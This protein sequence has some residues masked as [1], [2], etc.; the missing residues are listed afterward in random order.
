[1]AQDAATRPLTEV[2]PA[3]LEWLAC[4]WGW[5]TTGRDARPHRVGSRSRE[6]FLGTLHLL[7]ACAVDLQLTPAHKTLAWCL[8][9][10]HV[11]AV[12]H[13][14]RQSRRAPPPPPAVA[15]ADA[16]PLPAVAAAAA[17]APPVPDAGGPVISAGRL[18]QFAQAAFKAHTWLRTVDPCLS[19]QPTVRD[20]ENILRTAM[21]QVL[22]VCVCVCVRALVCVVCARVCVRACVCMGACVSACGCVLHVP[23]VLYSCSHAARCVCARLVVSVQR[24]AQEG[25]ETGQGSQERATSRTELDAARAAGSR[26]ARAEDP[27]WSDGC[28][29]RCWPSS[30][31][32]GGPSLPAVRMR[33]RVRVRVCVCVCVWVLFISCS[34]RSRSC[35]AQYLAAGLSRVA[36]APAHQQHPGYG[37]GHQHVCDR[38]HLVGAWPRAF[39]LFFSPLVALCA[40]ACS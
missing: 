35:V 14:C 12:L 31:A 26:R 40:P 20:A 16:A 37:R 3:L 24:R 21:H 11:N 17:A 27:G 32:L 4:P 15:A 39:I 1:M 25:D 36:S 10:D 7:C 18:Y 23:R 13:R 34:L 5:P 8:R 2:E 9:P 19:A 33:A 30:P 29:P 22:C 38:R 6:A 28:V